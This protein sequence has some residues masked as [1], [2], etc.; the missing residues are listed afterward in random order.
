MTREIEVLA[1]GSLALVQD[2]GR[3][4]LAS[5]GVGRSGAADRAALKLANRMLANPESAAG[6]E[7][8]F[9]GLAVRAQG[10]LTV[11]ITGAP[12]PVAG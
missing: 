5:S 1:T 7:V 11:A 4:G 3:P 9:G 2:L 12:V 10:L 6:I 8:V